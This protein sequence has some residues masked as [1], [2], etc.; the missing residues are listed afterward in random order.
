MT[1]RRNAGALVAARLLGAAAGFGSLLL[2]GRWLDP[3]DFGRYVTI[4]VVVAVLNV[5]STFGIDDVVVR[6]VA[7]RRTSAVAASIRLQLMVVAAALAVLSALA[8]FDVEPVSWWMV[9]AGM[10]LAPMALTSSAFALLRGAER[11]SGVAAAAALG[12]GVQLAGVTVAGATGTGLGGYVVAVLVSQLVTAAAG[13]YAA[14]RVLSGFDAEESAAW[15]TLELAR[16]SWRFAVMVIAT[17][18]MTQAGVVAVAAVSG[19]VA[20]GAHGLAVRAVEAA[21]L[22]P[23]SGVAVVFPALARGERPSALPGWRAAMA[24]TAGVW[25][26]SPLVVAFV[27]DA[28]ELGWSLRWLALALPAVVWRLRS[29]AALLASDRDREVFRLAVAMA[30]I[31][32]AAVALGAAIGD[33]VGAS[34]A[35]A[36]V[37]WMH[38]TALARRRASAT[39]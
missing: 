32:V 33:A 21:R 27:G 38:A 5:V 31:A 34:V 22:L 6:S 24:V 16:N 23:A 25:V 14:V 18:V 12:G 11:L 19:D 29:S 15:T 37:T 36:A 30:P 3:E 7:R 10:G 20:A 39:D 26:A 17:A 1:P 35:V 2:A 9:I 13:A 4:V 8:M 28:G